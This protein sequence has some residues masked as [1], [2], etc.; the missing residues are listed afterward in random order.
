MI[1]CYNGNVFVVNIQFYRDGAILETNRHRNDRVTIYFV[2]SRFNDVVTI[3]REE[4]SLYLYANNSTKVVYI[5]TTNIK[6]IGEE[7]S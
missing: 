3:L 6:P 4:K 2:L 7:E 1:H 5:T